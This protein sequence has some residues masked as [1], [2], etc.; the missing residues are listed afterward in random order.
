VCVHQGGL[1]GQAVDAI[2]GASVT[3][4]D[5][6]LVGWGGASDEDDICCPVVD[7][8]GAGSNM[9]VK[10]CTLQLHPNSRYPKIAV[11]VRAIDSG[12]ATASDCKL[13]G[14][15]PGSSSVVDMAAGGELNGA[16][17]LVSRVTW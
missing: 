4:K 15:A 5:S 2:A 9:T 8:S 17:A 10:G 14:P 13:I 7:A 6:L 3:C 12:S 1:G 11:V 16:V